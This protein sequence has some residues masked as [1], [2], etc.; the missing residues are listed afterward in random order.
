MLEIDK[1]KIISKALGNFDGMESIQRMQTLQEIQK[2]AS[3]EV[4][5]KAEP[6]SVCPVTKTELR[7]ACE[8]RGCKFW[9]NHGWAK[10][11]ALN[12]MLNQQ[13]DKLTVEQVSML[14]KKSPQRV[15]S[16]YKRAFKIVQRHYL[17]EVIRSRS[18]PQFTYLPGFCP[19]CQSQLLEEELEDPQL[20]LGNGHGYC[21][22]ECKKVHPP[23]YFEIERFFEADFLRVVDV[24]S[25][26]FNFFYLEEILG[27]Q[28]NVLRNR[29]EKLRDETS[30]KKKDQPSKAS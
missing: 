10:N 23:A 9:V 16:I 4:T 8:L 22:P 17:R 27:F 12:F 19:A 20:S 6:Q 25:E 2:I 5:P 24:G 26:L 7:T 15:E 13:K 28:P 11:C 3:V 14:Y 21:S 30:S 1:L 18:V 29:L